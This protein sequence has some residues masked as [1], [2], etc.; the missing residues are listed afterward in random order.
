[1]EYRAYLMRLK[2]EKINDYIEI[3]K[4]EKIWKSVVDGL[5]RAGFLKM[6]IFQMGQDLILFEEADNLKK[7][8]NF[9]NADEESIRWEKKIM[10]WMEHNPSWNDM[11]GN[12]E[13][14]EVPIV[15]YFEN[16]I[17]KH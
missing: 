17:M 10:E 6:V 2:N 13:F 1:M 14:T 11:E 16:G 3:H 15:Y 8:Y 7:A 5:K 9:L 4:K 12:I